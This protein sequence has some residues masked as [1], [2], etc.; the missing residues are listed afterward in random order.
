MIGFTKFFAKFVAVKQ[1]ERRMKKIL[2]FALITL[3]SC[4]YENEIEK[5]LKD[6]VIKEA[7]KDVK[8]E[9][10]NYN[11]TDTLKVSD[12]L[13]MLSI[14]MLENGNLFN[15]ATKDSLL[16]IRNTEFPD[17]LTEGITLEII[18]RHQQTIDSLV[19]VWDNVSPYSFAVNYEEIWFYNLY[20][21]S[22]GG[23]SAESENRMNWMIENRSKYDEADTLSKKDSNN[24]Y[25]YRIE[26][27][28]K[29]HNDLIGKSLNIQ[30]IVIFDQNLN[31]I[32]SE[33]S[34]S[35]DDMIKQITE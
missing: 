32:S 10:V 30:R 1:I 5:A 15:D 3:V 6:S 19:A 28:Y 35:M 25:G 33:I 13:N 34:N 26:H 27:S 7:G 17:Y 22:L 11:V 9:L 23:D 24:I 21:K 18:K 16:Q 20:V 4:A 31:L 14:E 12:R 29:I 8:Y 2:L